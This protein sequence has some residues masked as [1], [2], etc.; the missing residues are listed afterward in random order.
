VN[1]PIDNFA[2]I[3]NKISSVL[4]TA[5]STNLVNRKIH[6]EL[7]AG[8]DGFADATQYKLKTT[9]GPNEESLFYFDGLTTVYMPYMGVQWTPPLGSEGRD[10][11]KLPLALAW[12]MH[13]YIAT[14]LT[15]M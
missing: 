2:V 7:N 3:A 11:S 5:A 6:I 13:P 4:D 10:Y 12:C 9:P 1:C 8:G 15:R 14:W